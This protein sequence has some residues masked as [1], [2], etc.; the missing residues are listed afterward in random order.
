[1]PYRTLSRPPI[2]VWEQRA[3]IARLREQGR[4]DVDEQALF[5]MVA[6]MRE[7]TE[8]A[9]ATTRKVRR[10]RERR[11]ATPVAA[12]SMPPPPEVPAAVEAG[13]ARPFGVIEQ[14]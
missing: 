3:A 1:V 2:S 11:T 13:V 6:Q 12:P 14:W 5:A 7:I 10:D 8:T 4:A 9:A